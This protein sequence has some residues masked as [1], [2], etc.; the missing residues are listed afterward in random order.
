M[1]IDEDINNER[2]LVV[3]KFVLGSDEINRGIVLSEN[4]AKRVEE[5]NRTGHVESFVAEYNF[6]RW[7]AQCYCERCGNLYE[8]PFTLEESEKFREELHKP[9]TI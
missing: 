9:M 5:C 7:K 6:N 3:E 2:E 8:R 4:F 1:S